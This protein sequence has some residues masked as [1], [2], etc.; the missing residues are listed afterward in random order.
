MQN[1]VNNRLDL[2]RTGTRRN[3]NF[4]AHSVSECA[5]LLFRQKGE[6]MQIGIIGGG[7]VGCCLAAYF[8]QA[9]ILQGIT[10]AHAEKTARL[11]AK[12]AVPVLSN[13]ELAYKSEIIFITVPDRSIAAAAEELVQ[14]ADGGML[15]G[16]VFLHC[17]GSLGLESLAALRAAGAYTGSCHPLQS[18]A[19]GATSLQGVYMAVDGD[20]TAAAA[21]ADIVRLLGGKPF[22]VP[23][24]DRK[25]YHAAACFCSNYVVAAAAIG[26]QIME[27]WLHDKTAAWQALLPLFQGTAANLR[28]AAAAGQAL[29]GP[30]ARGDCSTV[31]GHL[32]VLP[33]EYLSAYCSLGLEAVQ[34]ALANGTIDS[35]TVRQLKQLLQNPEVKKHDR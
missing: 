15:S 16:K 18:F 25:L 14:Q 13:L 4:Y 22:A 20:A 5:F 19:G 12:F 26:Q 29:T 24:E 3:K 27:R 17:S 34:L 8:Q 7:K 31:S 2:N 30:I 21:A 6:H 32:E 9:G 1:Y 35:D 11:A 33:E 23:P 28:Q 10:A